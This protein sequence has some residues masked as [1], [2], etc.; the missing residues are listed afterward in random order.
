MRPPKRTSS[1]GRS[2]PRILGPAARRSEA[3]L[4]IQA[5]AV[6]D[7]AIQ[8]LINDWIAPMIADHI[9]ESIVKARDR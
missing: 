1:R 2:A 7:I 8:G 5:G 3:T 6:S 9:I 4:E